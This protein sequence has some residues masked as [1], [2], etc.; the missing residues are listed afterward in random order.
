MGNTLYIGQ[1]KAKENR[2]I[3]YDLVLYYAVVSIF[4]VSEHYF[5]SVEV[6]ATDMKVKLKYHFWEIVL[7]E[8]SGLM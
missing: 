4:P 6:I 8:T 1:N 7:G 5:E 2:S 3:Y